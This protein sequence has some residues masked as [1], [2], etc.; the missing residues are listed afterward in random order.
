MARRD[1][2]APGADGGAGRLRRPV[3]SRRLRLHRPHAGGHHRRRRHQ[4]AARGR[5]RRPSR[6]S[7][8]TSSPCAS[9]TSSSRAPSRCSS[10]TI[11]P[12]AG[13][14]PAWRAEVVAGIGEGC[15]QAGCALIGGETA[16][17]PGLYGRGE[18]D[19]AGFAVG[20]VERE[21][22]AAAHRTASPRATW[23]SASPPPACTPTASRWS[24][25]C[26]ASRAW[27][28]P[29]P[30]PWAPGTP[31]ADMLLA[32]TRI[33]VASLPRRHRRRRRQGA[34]A[35]HR[36]RAGREPAARAGRGPGRCAS[37]SAPGPLPPVFAWLARAGRLDRL[38]LLR[39]FNCG[40]GMVLVVDPARAEPVRRALA[41]AGETVHAS[42]RI[43][44]RGRPAA[45]RVRRP[46]RRHGPPPRR[47]PDLGRRLQPPGADRRHRGA[48]RPAP[49]SCWSISNR[50]DA[51]GLPARPRVP[52]SRPR[53]S[54]TARSPTAPPSRPRIDGAL[55]EAGDRAGLPRRLHA[56]P[57]RRLRRA[58]G[59]T[60]CST[61]IPRCCRPS[62]ACDTHAR[63]LAAGVPGARLHRASGPARARRRADPGPGR[64]ARCWPATMRLRSA[65]RVLEVEHRCYP[66]A[67]E[68]LASG[69]SRVTRRPGRRRRARACC[70]TRR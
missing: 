46:R 20:A 40:I 53:R 58:P 38:E 21:R 27:G 2:A 16:E 43:A 4:G 3:R 50:A 7:A 6:A 55:R 17:M 32:P 61:S 44:A 37:T 51:Y 63:A 41:A 22:R 23:C 29:T 14:C 54:I 26:C 11:S 42:A 59:T 47:G 69:C 15:R 67:L 10:S 18:F 65:A 39:T 56:H 62:P 70:S 60:G 35:H 33:Y 25:W 57:D 45:G 8:S 36:R 48:R 9:T 49:R 34:G 31:L 24:A 64:G 28:S 19:L 66:L 5:G 1:R 68:L 30:A 13:W 52:A 12:P